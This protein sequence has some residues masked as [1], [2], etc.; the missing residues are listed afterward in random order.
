[1]FDTYEIGGALS[2]NA[3]LVGTSIERN[4]M[5]GTRSLV[6]NILVPALKVMKNEINLFKLLVE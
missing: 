3:M 4:S 6:M 2:M 1:M 5:I